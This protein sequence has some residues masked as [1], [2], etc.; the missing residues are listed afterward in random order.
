MMIHLL[1]DPNQP[2]DGDLLTSELATA[3][4]PPFPHPVYESSVALIPDG[5]GCWLVVTS[6]ALVDPMPSQEDRLACATQDEL[7]TLLWSAAEA[8]N[9]ANAAA[10]VAIEAIIAAHD[11]P[12]VEPAPTPAEQLEALGARVAELES[13]LGNG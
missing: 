7:D 4:F 5:D 10:R 9:D 11:P 8:A 13:L 3:G 1:H 12:V 6:P 2:I